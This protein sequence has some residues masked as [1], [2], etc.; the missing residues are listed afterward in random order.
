MTE[1]CDL[2]THS[3]FSDGMLSPSELVKMATGKGLAAIALSDHDNLDGFGELSEVGAEQGVEVIS[4]VEL[5]CEQNGRDLHILGYG[6]SPDNSDFQA[7]LKRFRDTREERGLK[8]I[9]KLSELGVELD[10]KV[11]LANAGN[12]ALGRPHIA[13]ALVEGGHVSD[14][15]QAFEKY[16]GEG[17]PAHV[18]K[19]KMSPKEAVS[20]IHDA[21]GLAFVA[22]PGFYLDDLEAFEDLIAGGFD[23]IEVYHPHHNRETITQ[24]LRIAE[25]H[26]VLVSGGSDFH[27]FAGRDNMG[28]PKVPYTLLERITSRLSE[29][30]QR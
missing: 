7:V 17:C 22:H 19:Y 1:L 20:H 10:A 11:V 12:G 15:P 5:S 4:G 9:E 18:D 30:S 28:E 23:G 24:L 21:G 25:S 27:G 8:I 3:T 29:R 26:D 2:H 14:F 6:V 16:I 13:K